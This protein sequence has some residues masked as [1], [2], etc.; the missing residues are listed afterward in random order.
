MHFMSLHRLSSWDLQV[1]APHLSSGRHLASPSAPSL[2]TVQ[3]ATEHPAVHMQ[4][5]QAYPAY[6]PP[7]WPLPWPPAGA[8]QSRDTLLL[9]YFP[10]RCQRPP[11]QNNPQIPIW[12]EST[13]YQH[14]PVRLIKRCSPA[15]QRPLCHIY[16]V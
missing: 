3:G 12:G 14:G 11:A 15:A 16:P 7:I 6:C 4:G 1:P 9:C 8:C 2:S 13:A 10:S 5:L